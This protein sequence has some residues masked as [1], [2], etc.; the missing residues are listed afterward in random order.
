M[1]TTASSCATRAPLKKVT[2]HTLAA[3]KARQ[4]V[5]ADRYG[6]Y[7]PLVLKIAPDL[8]DAQ[9]A[10][11]ADALRRHRIDGVIATSIGIAL[12]TRGPVTVLIGDV[13]FVHDSSS[14]V[15]IVDHAVDLHIVL[16]DNRGGGIFSFLPQATA[17][18]EDQFEKLF[19]TPHSTDVE[20]LCR[21]FPLYPERRA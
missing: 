15:N 1:T 5:L 13:A 11:I 16:I 8:D 17:L 2:V 7:V 20:A 18:E 4:T 12:G 21:K 14:L 19:G 6:R 9:I 10:G 3:L